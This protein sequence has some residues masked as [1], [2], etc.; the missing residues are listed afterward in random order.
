LI[1]KEMGKMKKYGLIVLSIV[2]CFAMILGGCSKT[3]EAS[4]P[5]EQ[6]SGDAP[7]NTADTSGDN[8]GET[9][10]ESGKRIKV[11]FIVSDPSQG[12]WKEV[13]ESLQAACEDN[14][15]DFTYQIVKD[16]AQ[17]RFAFDSLIA[18]QVDII[19]D[20]YALEEIAVAYAEEAVD[21]GIPFLGVAFKSPVEGAY[22][23]GTSNEGL[24]E[25]LGKSAIEFIKKEWNGKVDLIITAN[26][27]TAVPAMA[28]R[29][30]RAAELIL[31]EF[32]SDI[33]WVK[34]D[35][36]HDFTSFGS[37]TANTLTAHPGAKNIIYFACTDTVVPNIIT[38]IEDAGF[39]EK[40]M[41]LSVDCTDTFK[42]YARETA[43]LGKY[44]PWYGSTDLDTATYGYKLL[45]KVFRILDG[46]EKDY[47]T[48]HTG[49][50]ITAD[51]ID[52]HYPE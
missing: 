41:L 29:T 50:M 3:K 1:I 31:E 12:F 30:D 4:V 2:L 28:S 25:Q 16:S 10:K 40:V 32:G 9:V 44:R 34:L 20:G 45:D 52:E 14:D 21:K 35:A 48:E 8:S 19:L 49:V 24:G 23:Y 38:A 18:Q 7:G 42:N 37:K 5:E 22:S 47:Y 51:N 46:T 39:E 36:E 43:K 15:V 11:G 17:M 33:E 26:A 6:T 13:L 27:Y